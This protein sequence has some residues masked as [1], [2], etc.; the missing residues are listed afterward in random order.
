MASD[1]YF[2]TYE[3][4]VDQI[5]LM[6]PPQWRAAMTGKVLKRLIVAIAISIEQLYAMMARLLRLSII[7]TSEGGWL[8][9]IVA[10]F[11]METYGGVAATVG[12]RF[13]RFTTGQAISIPQGSQVFAV[14]GQVFA[15]NLPII[16]GA[17]QEATTIPCTCTTPGV[18]GNIAAGSIVGLVAAITGIDEVSNPNPGAGGDAAESDATIKARIPG[19]L[20]SLHRATIPATEGAIALRR[21]LFPSVSQFITQRNYGTPGYF[22][23]ILSDASG[24]DLYRA[25]DWIEV[26]NGVYYLNTSLPEIGGLVSAGYPCRR[27]GTLSRTADG[28]EVWL[29]SSYVTQVEQGNWRYCH[30]KQFGRLYAKA[31]GRSLTEF[32]ITI[33]AGVVAQALAELESQW[34]GNGIY[35]DVLVPFLVSGSISISYTLEP[36]RSQ[37]DVESA[38]R[39]AISD[40]ARSLGMG[41]DLELEGLYAAL[42]R[43][44][45]AASVT[46]DAPT[47]NI[48]VPGDSVFRMTAPPTITRR[49]Q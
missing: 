49:A 6:L 19:Y 31:D 13:S 28:A 44:A 20:A 18:Q 46:I 41:D 36:L 30:D 12:V 47:F 37:F 26:S 24:G 35:C 34:A 9:A 16:L 48:V 39:T 38:L 23:A 17:D 10:G 43:V 33:V 27:F 25:A 11:G 8:K 42:N 7:A 14:G 3:E 45:G 2:L 21:D 4:I 22:R 15:T 32:Q 40:Y 1:P 29:P 5:I